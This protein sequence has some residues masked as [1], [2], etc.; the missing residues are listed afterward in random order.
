IFF[1]ASRNALLSGYF[2][3]LDRTRRQGAEVSL[4]GLT[5][6][7]RV[8]WFAKYAYTRAT[9]ASAAQIFSIRSDDDF[10]NSNLAGPNTVVPGDVI[11]L[12]PTHQAKAGGSLQITPMLS[13]G[14]DGRY[15]GSQ[16]VRG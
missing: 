2:T 16:W 5:V 11:P 1:V 3:N 4:Q 9:F 13:L 15:I 10:E 7:D 14:L 8:D 12:V 6:G